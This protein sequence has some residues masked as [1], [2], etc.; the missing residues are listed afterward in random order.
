MAE[1][2][3]LKVAE[4]T[5]RDVGRGIARLDPEDMKGIGA[6]V[7]D[8]ISL[9]GKKK[10][11]AKVMPAYA[12]ERGKKIIQVDGIIRE[13]GQ[14]GLDEKVKVEK[15]EAKPA[16]KV[17]LAPLTI[18]SLRGDSDTKY[19]GRLLEGLALVAGDR[20][21]AN[22]FG[23]RSCDFRVLDTRP[24]DAVLIQPATLIKIKI[25][26][27]AE[28][29][30][31]LKVSYED[32]GGLN[33]QLQRVRELVELPLRYP[34]VFD[35]L[36]IEAPKGIFLYGPPGCGKTLLARTVANETDAYFTSISGPEIMGKFYGESEARLRSIFEDAQANAPAIIF[37]DEIESI[38]PKR[39]EM[40]A[41]K[42]VER[43]VVAQLLAL[44][45]GLQA[46]G[47]IVVIGATN[48]PNIVDPALRR[49]GRFDR[50]LEIPIP[51]KNG[52]LDILHI[53]SR[54]MP[55]AKDVDLEKLASITHGFVGADLESLARE[56][57]MTC[58]R[59]ILP[60]VDFE[61]ADIPYELLLE[62]EVT[63]DNFME[64]LKEIEP[65]A[66]R[67]VFVEVPDVKWEDVGGLEEVKKRLV[68]AIEWPLQYP[69]LFKKA[70]TNPPKGIL[71]YGSP[72]TGKTLLAKAVAN[73]SEVNFITIKGPQLVSKFVGESEKGI[74]DIFRKAKQA[75]PCILFFDEIDSIVPKRSGADST[76]VTERVISQFLTEMDGI[77]EL[78]G[79]VVLG[80]T[81]R[82]DIV[83]SAVI[84]PGRFDLLLEL[85]IP[86]EK[87]RL[88]IFKIHTKE[89]PLHKEIELKELV[90]K[91]DKF[92]GADI[93]SI[94]RSASILAIRDVIDKG[95]GTIIEDELKKFT[96]RKKH[97][98]K[99]I[100]SVKKED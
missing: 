23:T 5:S 37:L 85:P 56:A 63:M 83:D 93:E 36:G 74:R 91:T 96:I 52:R 76:H 94:A 87:T 2:I 11:V 75:S 47:Q 59:K 70:D 31:G 58:L 69:E 53:H 40:G 61:L 1:T 99:A 3:S 35:R 25:E 79:V 13:N 86:D 68:E 98:E 44:M 15:I 7:G 29:R 46:R 66:I 26:E 80:A 45:D 4:A 54:G 16:I 28:K 84:R 14:I 27:V 55:L 39:E 81:N 90:D 9:T 8:I 88:D 21:R 49:P 41:E 43:R 32:V 67:E 48:L 17:T 57:A 10:T 34:Q 78:K 50:E 73:V 30:R 19:I 71:L 97:F 65:S 24:E 95:K 72:G 38:A 22:L 89:K 6:S 18:S 51:D 33:K 100:K 20:V 42:Q 60:K 82:L 62:L 77:E 12:E 64:A 92:T